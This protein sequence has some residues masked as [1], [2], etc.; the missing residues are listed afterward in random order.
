MMLAARCTDDV[1]R[2]IWSLVRDLSATDCTISGVVSNTDDNSRVRRETSSVLN[3]RISKEFSVSK[4][5]A[6]FPQPPKLVDW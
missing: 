5:I 3:R 6:A 1:G 2:N 4:S